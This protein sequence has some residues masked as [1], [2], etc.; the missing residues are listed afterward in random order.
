VVSRARWAAWLQRSVA[1]VVVTLAAN[2]CEKGHEPTTVRFVDE[3]PDA[4]DDGDA[5]ETDGARDATPGDARTEGGSRD[6]TVRIDS[7][8]AGGRE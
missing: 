7:V 6:A 5:G 2:G 1:T 8:P 3:T 4:G